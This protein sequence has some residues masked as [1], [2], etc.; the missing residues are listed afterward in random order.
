MNK[1]VALLMASAALIA[2]VYV[3]VQP[4]APPDVKESIDHEHDLDDVAMLAKQA[5]ELIAECQSGEE[6][7]QEWRAACDARGP[8]MDRLKAKG[9]C[10]DRHDV[11][12]ARQYWVWCKTGV[13]VFAPPPPPRRWYIQDSTRTTCIETDSPASK[14]QDLQ[15]LDPRTKEYALTDT[16]GSVEVSY[17]ETALTERVYRFWR[18]QA[19]C[20]RWLSG[21]DIPN[22]YR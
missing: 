11:D 20:E 4:T 15:G 2:V 10:W 3:L 18:N 17:A 5:D 16:S 9:V 22:K 8:A 1:N 12:D 14:I 13:E 7:E 6:A 19:E 21:G